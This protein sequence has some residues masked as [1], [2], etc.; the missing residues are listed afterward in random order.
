MGL[1]KESKKKKKPSEDKI[2]I[3]SLNLIVLL[4]S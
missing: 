3:E 1:K 2:E 4:Y